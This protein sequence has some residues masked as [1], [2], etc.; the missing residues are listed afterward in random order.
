MSELVQRG[1]SDS[2]S[3]LQDTPVKARAASAQPRVIDMSRMTVSK[4][5]EPVEV[6][7][8]PVIDEKTRADNYRRAQAPALVQVNADGTRTWTHDIVKHGDGM[9]DSLGVDRGRGTTESIDMLN[10]E[11]AGKVD[12]LLG[13]SGPSRDASGKFTKVGK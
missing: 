1:L 9:R 2:E 5:P 13:K 6:D 4:A 12:G 10:K 11:G 8:T 3:Y 7:R